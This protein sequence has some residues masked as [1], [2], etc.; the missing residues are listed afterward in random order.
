M[1]DK[2]MTPKEIVE[3]LKNRNAPSFLLDEERLKNNHPPLTDA[4]K[5]EYA[6]YSINNFK[7]IIT[8]EY[9]LSCFYRFGPG[10]IGDFAFRHG[11]HVIAVDDEVI[12]T[13]LTHQIDNPILN[14]RPD[15]GYQALWRFYMANDQYEKD[16]GHKWMRDF[17]DSVFIKG[18]GLLTESANQPVIH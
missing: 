8:S 17:I 13:L 1:N 14:K 2:E 5:L 15:E 4:E 9:Q 18:T 7:E 12:N 16:T 3:F 10:V 11:D 6:K